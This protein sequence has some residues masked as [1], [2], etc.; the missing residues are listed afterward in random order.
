[1]GTGESSEED[2]SEDPTRTTVL[3]TRHGGEHDFLCRIVVYGDTGV[4]K[5]SLIRRF[6]DET[7]EEKSVPTIGFDFR[8]RVVN[9]NGYNCKY[10][11]WDS[12]GNY[13]KV[14]Y[15]FLFSR[16]HPIYSLSRTNTRQHYLCRNIK[17]QT[18]SSSCTMS[19][20]QNHWATSSLQLWT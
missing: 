14:S 18:Q 3:P 15:P 16:L 10:Q 11:I 6:F 8:R 13:P 4:G 5:T 19:I 7:F 17:K 9:F 1:M 12:G 2:L 20:I